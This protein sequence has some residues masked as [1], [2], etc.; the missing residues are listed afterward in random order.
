MPDW[1]HIHQNATG[2]GSGG[3]PPDGL[4]T[5][6]LVRCV[7]QP[8]YDK[9]I[10]EWQDTEGHYWDSWNGWDGQQLSF[11]LDLLRGLGMDITAI[12]S[13]DE[14]S[15]A[16]EMII[17]RTYHVRTES[18]QYNGKTYINTYY[19]GDTDQGVQQKLADVPIEPVTQ[20]AAATATTP[21]D[22]DIPF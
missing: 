14:F 6:R 16:A 22:D 9:V 3:T 5:A 2:A 15:T 13:D 4:H 1:D 18:R 10:T 21:A 12:A 7:Q 17:D 11:T 19:E 20:P 8:D